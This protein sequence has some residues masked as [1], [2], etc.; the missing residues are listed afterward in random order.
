MKTKNAIIAVAACAAVITLAGCSKSNEPTPVGSTPT[1]AVTATDAVQ[2]TASQTVE[3]AKD[4]A[5]Q[6]VATATNVASSATT[7]F[8]DLVAQ[9]KTY[10]TDKKY[11]EA[12]DSLNKLS[13]LTLTPEQQKTLDD[14]K[15]EVTKLMA[16]STGAVDAA[17]SLFGK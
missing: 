5:G 15:A 14:L 11:T 10:I 13:N 16:G 2:A 12:M 1:N 17:K 6:V 4:V 8:N 3:A 9:A 7:Q